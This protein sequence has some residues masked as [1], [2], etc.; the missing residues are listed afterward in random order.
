MHLTSLVFHRHTTVTDGARF[1]CAA[2]DQYMICTISSF[3]LSVHVYLR[4]GIF[5]DHPFPE[6]SLRKLLSP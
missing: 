3:S 4:G 5:F 1:R 2:F 6:G